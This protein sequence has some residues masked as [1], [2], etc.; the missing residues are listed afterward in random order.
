[1]P[2]VIVDS[3]SRT[4]NDR[5][6]GGGR[7]LGFRHERARCPPAGP[8]QQ[9]VRHPEEERERV[10]HVRLEARGE[11]DD[12]HLEVCFRAVMAVVAL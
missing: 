11:V 12:G 1:M 3:T 10:N 7:V 8:G 2:P 9:A 5:H 6:V 4:E